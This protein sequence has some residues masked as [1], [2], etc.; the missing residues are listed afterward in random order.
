MEGVINQF[1]IYNSII[2]A[3]SNLTN[4]PQISLFYAELPTF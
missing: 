3:L 1:F 2:K 4:F